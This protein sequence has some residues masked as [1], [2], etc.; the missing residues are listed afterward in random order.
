MIARLRNSWT[1]VRVDRTTGERPSDDD[2]AVATAFRTWRRQ[3]CRDGV[4]TA[5]LV[6]IALAPVLALTDW[7]AYP[8]AAGGLAMLRLAVMVFFAL[9]LLVLRTAFGER[10]VAPI[11]LVGAVS[12]GLAGVVAAG[13][14][15]GF[16]SPYNAA[17]PLTM[18]FT[19]LL[20]PWSAAW[21][22]GASA[23][24][25]ALS[26]ARPLVW[27]L[28]DGQVYTTSLLGDT[29]IAGLV[30][31]MV[32]LRERLQ[33][34]TFRTQRA[35]ESAYDQK[36]DHEAQ[37]RAVLAS[38]I[39]PMITIDADGIVQL[40]SDS[41]ARVFGWTP[42]E[43]VGQHVRV[44]I[45]ERERT[46]CEA[47][48][49][50][51]RRQPGEVRPWTGEGRGLRLDGS[52]FACEVTAWPLRR[53]GDGRA[54]FT[55]IV[56]DVSERRRTEDALRLT[57]ERFRV[58]AS[59]VTDALW[60]WDMR[61]GEVWYAE[62]A[63]A[64]F[65]Y[66]VSE[67]G[68]DVAWWRDKIHPD[69][70]ARVVATIEA[71]LRGDGA[72]WREEFRFRR[73]DGSYVDIVDHGFVMRDARG[74]AERMIGAMLDVTERNR[75][76]A[77]LRES[78][79]R[80]KLCLDAARMGTWD[81]DLSTG[82]V[83]WSEGYELLFGLP[84]GGFDGRIATFVGLVH[85]DD[86]VELARTLARNVANGTDHVAE[87]RIVW[88]D[89][90]V[91]WRATF[92][93]VF[94]D[95]QD[96]P[97]RISGVGM[98]VTERRRAEEELRAARDQAVEATRLKSEFLANMSHEIRT[99]MNGVIGMTDLAL[100]TELSA[101][102]R[103]Y[104]NAAR[105]SASDLLRILNDILDFSKIEAGKLELEAVP[106]P[107]RQ[108][109]G[110]TLRPLDV[111]ARQRGLTL[112]WAVAP[113][114]PEILVGDP[115][116]LRQ[117]VVNLV[118][119]AIKFTRHGE[120]VVRIGVETRDDAALTLHLSVRD[121]GIGIP[122]DKLALIFEPF[123]QA[124]GSTTREYGG[125]GLGLA[126]ARELV[127]RMGGALWV[128]STV[129]QGSTFH[130][131]VRMGVQAGTWHEE[132]VR[133]EDDPLA[134]HPP[135]RVLLAE[136]NPVNGQ[137]AVRLLER[138]GHRVVAVGDGRQALSALEDEEFDVVLMDVQM[139]EM[140]GLAATEAIRTREAT[141]GRHLPIVA[142]TAHAMKSDR[143]R[144][145]AAGVDAYVAK[146]IRAQ[147][148]FAAIA[149]VLPG[150]TSDGAA[151]RASTAVDPSP[152]GAV[153]DRRTLLDQMG[154]DSGLALE[155]V[156]L[157]RDDARHTLIELRAALTRGDA[158]RL[159]HAAHRLKGSLAT[160]AAGAAREAAWHVE[161]LGHA[162][163]LDDAEHAVAA[164][165]REL[166]RLEPEL[167]AF[168]KALR[169]G[170]PVDPPR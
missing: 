165:E 97:V 117:V 143:E 85:P 6:T 54:V 159:E 86:R 27:P 1:G 90:S 81:V 100:D 82:K 111:R 132:R 36:R 35:L 123:T 32:A 150:G 38:T 114:V 162:G 17:L 2:A 25:L 146:P 31:L 156:R 19:A 139:P 3:R 137:V 106:F 4:R 21:M 72:R 65:G 124:D 12:V 128:E 44:V 144:C 20:V 149:R 7:L 45:P 43:L 40:A 63:G 96:I 77:A 71:T 46:W 169:D 127:E 142:V 167:T 134:T 133:G 138:Q 48:L 74:K 42:R 61:T 107:I 89:G 129:G 26:A 70:R 78:D 102:Q 94:R 158:L 135:L 118:G 23:L 147:E 50:T 5:D 88:Q 62:N 153:L 66:L 79:A 152:G 95:A 68:A 84:P 122:A 116:R 75:A 55:G 160:L 28:D 166:A 105:S 64:K 37:L 39:D 76:Y 10:F 83:T 113:H 33:W 168:T 52:T 119:N 130:A 29:V 115:T 99:P 51:A 56:R 41:V 8:A 154:A 109:L 53:S 104:L 93:R 49:D 145:L 136:D 170:E 73:A 112:A 92:G 24:F 101:E 120:V 9:H 157:F 148:L 15:G 16:A 69:D 91:R 14:T 13:M 131:T 22:A 87:F 163:V 98:D 57:Q 34:R 141:T 103:E 151:P 67:V 30:V 18:V 108:R 164:L 58:V 60:D 140:D 126:I 121:T 11:A 125:T 59:V 80:L 161:T 47:A 110:E 155:A